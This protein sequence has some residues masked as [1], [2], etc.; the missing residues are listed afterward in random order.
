MSN[1]DS[2]IIRVGVNALCKQSNRRFGRLSP[3]F[4]GDLAQRERR[5]WYSMSFDVPVAGMKIAR[6]FMP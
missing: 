6:G 3:G 4:V 5:S 1:V 2:G